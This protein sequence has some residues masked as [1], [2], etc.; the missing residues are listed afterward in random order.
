MTTY[1][2]KRLGVET[3][4]FVRTQEEWRRIVTRNPF[5]AE[6]KVDPG[7][8][9][10]MCLKAEP[11]PERVRALQAAIT[12]REV[13]RVVGKQA[14]LVHPDGIGSSRLTIA[15]IERKFATRGTGRNWNTVLR[16]LGPDGG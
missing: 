15:L 8:L 1:L 11:E 10:V 14:Y 2:A 9:V 13:V 16:L 12:G 4:C 7:H 3:D 5:P 6:A